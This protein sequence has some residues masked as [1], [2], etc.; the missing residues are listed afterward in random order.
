MQDKDYVPDGT[1]K[2]NKRMFLDETCETNT[3]DAD[4]SIIE[5]SITH[6]DKKIILLLLQDNGIFD[7][8]FGS[9]IDNIIEKTPLQIIENIF[10]R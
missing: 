2:K 7:Q 9:N 5:N 10:L 6:I 8:W 1:H 3:S 4:R